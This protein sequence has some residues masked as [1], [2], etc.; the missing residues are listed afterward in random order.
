MSLSCKRI[1]V[2]HPAGDHGSN[3]IVPF[4]QTC[5][6]AEA[7]YECYY[8]KFAVSCVSNLQMPTKISRRTRSSCFVAAVQC[9]PETLRAPRLK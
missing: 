7:W 4:L 2:P 1:E 6:V 9:A 8:L 3:F 5:S